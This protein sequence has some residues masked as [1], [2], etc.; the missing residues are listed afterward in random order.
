MEY[1]L[2]STNAGSSGLN[3]LQRRCTCERNQ[4]LECASHQR[5]LCYGSVCLDMKPRRGIRRKGI[6][7]GGGTASLKVGSHCQTTAPAK[8]PPLL[9]GAVCPS[10]FLYSPLF[11]RLIYH[12]PPKSNFLNTKLSTKVI[13]SLLNSFLYKECHVSN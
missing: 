11:F 12:R 1:W 13:Q 10:V 6:A 5:L 3:R 8:L 7:P 2:N 9:S 4:I